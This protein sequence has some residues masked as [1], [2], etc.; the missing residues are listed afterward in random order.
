MIAELVL[1]VCFA[2][3]L[4][5]PTARQQAIKTGRPIVCWN[6]CAVPAYADE[7]ASDFVL[8][9]YTGNGPVGV[10]V[11]VCWDG[12]LKCWSKNGKE[13]YL[14]DTASSKDIQRLRRDIET[15]LL[16]QRQQPRL[17]LTVLSSGLW[18][19]LGSGGRGC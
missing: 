12:K 14:P 4:D 15:D 19:S 11:Y 2:P 3:V 7:L 6:N 16:R 13:A 9:N 10:T 17:P 18:G 1:A 8:A 5:W